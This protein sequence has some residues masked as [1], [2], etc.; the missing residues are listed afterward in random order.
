MLLGKD[1]LWMRPPG[2]RATTQDQ[3]IYLH[4]TYSVGTLP[5]TWTLHSVCINTSVVKIKM[6]FKQLYFVSSWSSMLLLFSRDFAFH[7]TYHYISKCF[8]CNNDDN[9]VIK[10]W[11]IDLVLKIHI[12]DMHI[13]PS[14]SLHSRRYPWEDWICLQVRR[15]EE[16]PVVAARRTC[17]SWRSEGNTC[18]VIFTWHVIRKTL[19]PSIHQWKML[20]DRFIFLKSVLR[21]YWKACTYIE[22]FIGCF[23]AKTHS[24]IQPK[25]L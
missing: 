8:C 11:N 18:C 3:W 16:G 6:R 24:K 15:I 2:D 17:C 10:K 5:T 25:L 22:R 1:R 14:P 23:C 7:C 4:Y 21:Q 13:W 12:C 20:K 19:C 9:C